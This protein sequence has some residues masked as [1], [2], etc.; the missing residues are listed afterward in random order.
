MPLNGKVYGCVNND[1][2]TLNED[3]YEQF[4]KL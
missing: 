3:W 2:M 1:N 4:V